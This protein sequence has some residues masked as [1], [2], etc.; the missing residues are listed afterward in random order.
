MHWDNY[1]NTQNDIKKIV[2]LSHEHDGTMDGG[3]E[4]FERSIPRLKRL[5]L[6]EKVGDTNRE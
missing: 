6:L 3:V 2:L 5:K 1:G 4:G